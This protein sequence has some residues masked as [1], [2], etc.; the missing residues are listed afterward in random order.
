M[1]DSNIGTSGE[2]D[3]TTPNNESGNSGA[4][5]GSISNTDD[6][7]GK[8]YTQKDMD[9]ANAATQR[10]TAFQSTKKFND[11]G[12][13]ETLKGLVANASA[14]T[15]QQLVDKGKYDDA[16][17]HV[18]QTKDAVIASQ[19]KELRELKIHEPLLRAAANHKSF[20]PEQTV[21]LLKDRVNMTPEGVVEVLDDAGAVRYDDN[22]KNFTVDALVK[23]FVANN[24][25]FRPAGKSTTNS[26]SSHETAIDSGNAWVDNLDMNIPA[27]VET[28]KK[29]RKAHG[30]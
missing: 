8:I 19:A 21:T 11:L 1:S 5:D 15:E 13:Y 7:A 3:S 12:D 30:M 2:T 9:D 22:G 6:Q 29:Y 4:T 26:N 16:L 23:E 10:N 18:N 28:Y 27:D 14:A 17:A 20:N 24:Q 25:H